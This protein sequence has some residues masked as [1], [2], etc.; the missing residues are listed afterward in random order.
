MPP[1]HWAYKHQSKDR[2]LA[3]AQRIGPETHAQVSA[4]FERKTYE[5]QA[6]RTIKG[7][8]N[9]ATRYGCE[10]LEEAC[11]RANSFDMVG[12]RRLKAILTSHL[13][14]VPLPPETPPPSVTQH[15]NLRGQTY[16]S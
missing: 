11:R 2:F 12:L 16:Y 14:A 13:D 15:D 9:L 8:Q 5:E 10:R 7:I 3:W 1:E 4:V 6:F